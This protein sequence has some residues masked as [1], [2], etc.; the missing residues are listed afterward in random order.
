M[1][2]TT[3]K[4]PTKKLPARKNRNSSPRYTKQ[5]L[6]KSIKAEIKESAKKK[7][8][9]SKILAKKSPK[10]WKLHSQ[11]RLRHQK[12]VQH[13]SRRKNWKLNNLTPIFSHQELPVK[14]RRRN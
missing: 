6:I 5:A 14:S 2:K 12:K 10:N 3:M 1:T 9:A 13:R 11:T 7:T 4:S 8:T